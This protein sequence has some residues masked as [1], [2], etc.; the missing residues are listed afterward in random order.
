MVYL[1]MDTIY[2]VKVLARGAFSAN[3]S[4]SY[5]SD[6]KGGYDIGHPKNKGLAIANTGGEY[7]VSGH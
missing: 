3:T 2:E 1:V 7:G 4:A 6:Q 5:L